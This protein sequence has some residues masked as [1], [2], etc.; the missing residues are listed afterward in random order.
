MQYNTIQ[1][2]TRQYKTIRYKTR[3]YKTR[4]YK[5][6]HNPQEPLE[7]PMA[8]ERSPRNIS[9]PLLRVG[10]NPR[11]PGDLPRE[12]PGGAPG[13]SPVDPQ[14]HHEPQGIHPT[15]DA[16]APRGSPLHGIP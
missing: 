3:Q 10:G 14:G 1:N 11:N 16:L 5:I 15:G 2:N 9:C 7:E 6:H 8:S 13:D 4:Q 12:P